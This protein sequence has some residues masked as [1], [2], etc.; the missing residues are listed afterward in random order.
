MAS[1]AL[2]RQLMKSFVQEAR[3]TCASLTLLVLEVER[4]EGTSVASSYES[5]FR[6]LHN[7]KGTSDALG[8]RAVAALAHE[9]EDVVDPY[10]RRPQALPSPLVDRMLSGL[11]ELLALVI[12]SADVAGAPPPLEPVASDRAQPT[13]SA[14]VREEAVVGVEVGEPVEQKPPRTSMA[15]SPTIAY[16]RPTGSASEGRQVFTTPPT[17]RG[18]SPGTDTKIASSWRVEAG[19]V[20]GLMR[21]VERLRELRLRLD[22]EL[23]RVQK[24]RELLEAEVPARSGSTDTALVDLRR[25][26]SSDRDEAADIVDALESSL[27]AICTVPMRVVVEPLQRVVRD[28]CRM[29]GKRAR[30][31]TSGRDVAIDRRVADA[32][33]SPLVH[34]V[35]NA[36]DHGIE[37]PETRV[38]LGKPAEGTVHVRAEQ[39]GNVVFVVIQ[40]DGSGIDID[41]I[42]QMAVELT[43]VTPQQAAALS[44]D[45]IEKLIFTSGLS[46][47]TS[48]DHLSGRGVGLDVVLRQVETLGGRVEVVSD[49]GRGTRFT[50]SLPLEL[51][52]FPVLVVRAGELQ[53][54][55]PTLAVER[56]ITA[57]PDAVDPMRDDLALVHQGTLLPL[58]DL[59]GVLRTREPL[60]PSA[61]QPVVVL[62]SQNERCAIV[63]DEVVGD[64]DLVIRP[65]SMELRHLLAY[66][67]AAT[68]PGG[69]LLLVLSADWLV[70]QRTTAP[71]RHAAQR[72]LVVDDSLTARALH[73]VM[74]E[75]GGYTVHTVGSGAHALELLARGRYDVVVCDIHMEGVDGYEL[76]RRTRANPRTASLPIV[77]VSN[78]DSD[79]DRRRGL[80]VGA[81]GF[82]GKRE[83]DGGRLLAEVNGAIGRRSRRDTLG[84]RLLA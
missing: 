65:L 79:E 39:Q 44:K 66:Q 9:L 71:A 69:E 62:S 4:A 73:R 58:L 77:L 67:G 75:A 1:E 52:S 63:V 14:P 83:C 8:L 3:E 61:G 76:T 60:A 18:S 2:R 15:S 55:L 30:L 78:L 40:D 33:K 7:L 11:D 72:A 19:Q 29:T 23:R 34:L 59:G 74:L 51:G 16:P 43:H 46:T 12:A 81:D 31:E 32:L 57:S 10:R 41:R 21:D 56:V 70:G 20:V 48:A 84:G 42:R 25:A 49:P 37:P 17:T 36:V 82:L 80:A 54:G 68:M 13:P 47:R 6:G 53:L 26:L 5:L 28:A 64:W 22:A 50:L 24:A 45:E 35:R 27:K 38:S